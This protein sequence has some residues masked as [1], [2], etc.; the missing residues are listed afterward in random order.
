MALWKTQPALSLFVPQPVRVGQ[1]F[2]VRLH[3]EANEAVPVEWID[4]T[5]EAVEGWAVGSGKNRVS[6]MHRYSKLVARVVDETELSGTSDYR[7]TFEIPATQPPSSQGG[8]AY[9]RYTIHAQASIPW[10]PDARASWPLA[11]RAASRPATAAPAVLQASA[12]ELLDISLESQRVAATGIVG[13]ILA[14]KKALDAP[15]VVDVTLREVLRLYSW[16]GYERVRHGRGFTTAVTLSPATG[17]QAPFRFRFDDAAPTFAAETFAHGWELAFAPRHGNVF[18][19]VVGMLSSSVVRVPLEMVESDELAS[20]SERLVAPSVGD[21][22]VSE[23]LGHVARARPTWAIDGMRIERTLESSFG[24]VDARIEW[25]SRESGTFLRA[26]IEPPRLGLS[27]RVRSAAMLDRLL[28]D[29][30][31]G[32]AEWDAKHH[33]ES[34]EGPQ[35]IAFLA[36]LALAAARLSMSA[37]DDTIELERP[38]PTIDQASLTT[39]VDEIDALLA[40]VPAALTAIPPPAGTSVD[41][42]EATRLARLTRG[43]FHPGDLALR[44]TIDERGFE[45]ALIF[46]GPRAV[47]LRIAVTDAPTGTLHVGP[48]RDEAALRDVPQASRAMVAALPPGLTISIDDGR[49]QAVLPA[50]STPH[51]GVD[52]ERSLSL[53]TTLVALARSLSPD[54]G[55]FR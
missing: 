4:L 17:G 1:P 48:E 43:T 33:V 51:F 36:P 30:T 23:I 15:L 9:V 25:I 54:A 53:A 14:T 31:V 46:E 38:D 24:P 37:N 29:T 49:A 50:P 22:R 40:E 16:N 42:T 39:F 35:A 7:A 52:H 20:V 34:R 11:V 13:G 32:V 12:S 6:R 18:A 27:L 10:W 5:L 45:A 47:A 3:V 55:P 41:R 21:A 8:T 28:G 19:A 2:S 44:G 26:V